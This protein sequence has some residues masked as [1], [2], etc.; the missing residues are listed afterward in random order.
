MAAVTFE[1]PFL[2]LQFSVFLKK[3]LNLKSAKKVVDI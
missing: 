2:W 3:V 1:S